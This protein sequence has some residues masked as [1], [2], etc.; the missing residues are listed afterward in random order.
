MI[1][2]GAAGPSQPRVVKQRPP[3][4]AKTAHT[5]D[6]GSLCPGACGGA[7]GAAACNGA[8]KPQVWNICSGLTYVA[9]RSVRHAILGCD[10]QQWYLGLSY[11]QAFFLSLAQKYKMVVA[12]AATAAIGDSSDGM[13]G[14]SEDGLAEGGDAGVEDPPPPPPNARGSKRPKV[15]YKPSS[16]HVSRVI[17]QVC[18]FGSAVLGNLS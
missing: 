13:A 7:C 9:V 6:I 18:G 14:G 3:H 12:V 10:T 11:I 1:D 16:V 17:P 2:P 8:C 4:S 15:G 5:L